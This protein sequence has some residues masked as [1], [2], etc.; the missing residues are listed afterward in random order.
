[1]NNGVNNSE[2]S[3]EPVTEPAAQQATTQVPVVAPA[4]PE[5]APQ[6]PVIETAQ[7]TVETVQPTVAQPAPAVV[8]QPVAQES[9]PVEVEQT[10]SLGSNVRIAP[11]Q[12]MYDE[13]D[14][15]IAQPEPTP[16]PRPA[17][18]QPTPPVPGEPPQIQIKQEETKEP[19]TVEQP[20]EQP[21]EL[22]PVV[23]QVVPKR[24]LS[25]TPLFLII[26]VALIG[27]I[28]YTKN[29]AANELNELKYQNIV[30]NTNGEK[31]ELDKK[32][33][34]IQDLYTKVAT[35]V[36]EDMANPN[37]DDEM[38]RYLAYRQINSNMIYESQC[39]LFDQNKIYSYKCDD[40]EFKP[41]AFK[42][43]TLDLEIKKIF[44]ENSEVEKGNIQL[45][46]QC[47]GGYEYIAERGEYVQG[48]CLE[49]KAIVIS[50]KK[51]IVSAYRIND[52]IVIEE[53]TKYISGN[54]GDIPETLKDGIYIYTFKLDTNLNYAYI[55]KD[56][57]TKY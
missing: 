27:Y 56:Y 35:T 49:N 5:Q 25:L 1:M 43:E 31:V 21:Q 12:P 42:E 30:T 3:I 54:K 39:N 53:E 17:I 47:I 7:P 18:T 33:T 19:T 29:D 6:A 52:Q 10:Q 15:V 28:I 37:L 20:P 36:R 11:A 9:A 46:R 41:N 51:E 32:S 44:G 24:R 45:G 26:I 23:E 50:A 48:Q 38:K 4:Q 14:N 55:S 40:K 34:L 57:R 8:A 2:L 16:P 22:A 13:N